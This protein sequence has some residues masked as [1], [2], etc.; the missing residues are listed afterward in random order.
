MGAVAGG[1]GG[2]SGGTTRS[3]SMGRR[4]FCLQLVAQG[5]VGQVHKQYSEMLDAGPDR[6]SR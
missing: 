5:M 4:A 6:L 1:P 3:G 2:A